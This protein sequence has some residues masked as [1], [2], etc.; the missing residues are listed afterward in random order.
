MAVLLN[1]EHPELIPTYEGSN[2]PTHPSVLYF[3][4]GWHGCE[5]WMA[6]TPY[7]FNNGS[8][9]DPSILVSHDGRAWQAPGGVTNPLVS[10][11]AVGHNCDVELCYAAEQ[12]ELR[13]YYVEADDVKQSWV[14]L[15][16]SSDGVHWSGPHTVLHDGAHMY[17]ILS[18]SIQQMADGSWQMWY[19]DTGDVGYKNQC[20][21]VRTRVSPDGLIWGEKESCGGLAQPG[22]QI[23]HL[24]VW[25]EPGRNT[26]HAFYPAYPNGSDCDYCSLFYACQEPGEPWTVYDKPVLDPAPDGAWDDFCIYRASFLLDRAGDGLQL[27]YGGKKKSDAS[28]GIGLLRTEYTV[29]INALRA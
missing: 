10:R 18:P 19:V 13:L 1:A 6:M 17:G 26:L 29:L 5:Y 28:W 8:Y 22:F 2:Q 11:P 27:W 23:W 21:R 16:R 25:R 7:P 24:S 14:K 9:E 15:L 3:P 20:N 12:D 4:E